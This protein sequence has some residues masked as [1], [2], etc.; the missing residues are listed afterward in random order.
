[1]K[2]S[3]QKFVKSF[4]LFTIYISIQTSSAQWIGDLAINNPVCNFQ[5]NQQDMQMVSDNSGGA[6]LTWTDTRNGETK[7]I[8]AQRI[9]ANGNLLWNADGIAICTAANEQLTP[10]IIS[11][12]VNGAIITWEDRRISNDGDIYAQRINGNGLVQWTING[13]TVCNATG[14]QSTPQITVDGYNGAIIAWTDGRNGN[15]D[16]NIY[17]QRINLVGNMQFTNN[18]FAVCTAA[19]FQGSPQ[20]VPDGNN[21]VIITWNDSRGNDG[22]ADIY[23]QRI[24]S[25]GFA[26]W[27]NNGVLI[28][29]ANNNQYDSKI[30][31]DSTGGAIIC[32]LDNRNGNANIYAQ[33]I[34]ATG[35]NQWATNGVS[36][37]S[38]PFLQGF[39]QIIS[40][41]TGGAYITWEDRRFGFGSDIYAQRINTTGLPLWTTDGIEVC[42]SSPVQ[43][44]PQLCLNNSGNLLITWQDDYTNIFAQAITPTGSVLWTTNGVPVCNA[45]NNQSNPQI[46][47]SG[48]N[49]VII[50]WDDNRSTVLDIYASKLSSSGTL[51]TK[52]FSETSKI[53]LFP[54]PVK[55]ILTIQN[56][57]NLNI[58][59]I[60]ITDLTGKKVLEQNN[61]ATS[62]NVENLQNGMYLLKIISEGKIGTSKFIKN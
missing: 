22:F 46:I 14:S 61:N 7:D 12:A 30:V 21:G 28:C 25:T 62:V 27:S 33:K 31:A 24:S 2:N 9:D 49:E 23:A 6:I 60:T 50:A 11:D 15:P 19:Y 43:K 3:V 34:S 1:M 13:V 5:G 51:T 32:W 17:T 57:E 20:L 44:E 45:I 29:N 58:D 35:L 16:A 36:V 38:A 39:Q 53:S 40:D 54:N 55:D 37:C 42:T 52:S 8:Y 18:G 48:Q 4:L 56:P 26:Y 41:N 47:S 10:K 59:K